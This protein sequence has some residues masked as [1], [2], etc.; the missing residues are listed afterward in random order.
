MINFKSLAIKLL[1][2]ENGI[3]EDA[4]QA[5]RDLGRELRMNNWL[6]QLHAQVKATEGRFY[7]PEDH[8]MTDE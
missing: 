7:L 1:D 5:L 2:D 8:T 6:T 3:S 4:Y